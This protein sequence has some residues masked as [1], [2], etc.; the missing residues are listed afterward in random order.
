MIT[1]KFL[2]T[3]SIMPGLILTIAQKGMHMTSR[4]IT[5]VVAGVLGL[6]I[7]ATVGAA[8]LNGSWKGTLTGA[9]GSAAEVQV[10][11]GP[12][13]F[14]LYSYTNN[15]GVMR[16]VELSRV[17]QTVEYVPAGGG[18][19]RVVVKS[20]DKAPGRLSVS[21]RGS[22]EKA[23]QGYL[24]QREEAALFEYSLS[25]EGLKMR[26]TTR[27]KSHFGDKDMI[28]GGDPNS[29]VAEGLLRKVQ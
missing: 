8:E 14:P 29:D 4:L 9:D 11:F 21:I 24:E 7:A 28:V 15:K 23:S 17:G 1:F 12:Q 27:S 3:S 2:P 22:F 10:D 26:V 16:Q 19:Q 18:V 5:G 25:P 6:M 13:G 20:L